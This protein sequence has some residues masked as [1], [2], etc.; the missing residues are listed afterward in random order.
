MPATAALIRDWNG[1]GL[2]DE[3][4]FAAFAAELRAARDARTPCERGQAAGL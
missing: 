3:Q 1:E 2:P 4:V